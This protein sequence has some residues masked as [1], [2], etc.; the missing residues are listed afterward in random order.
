[1]TAGTVSAATAV[2][3]G[4]GAD[5]AVGLGR[6]AACA[7]RGRVLSALG[8]GSCIGLVM[9]DVRL[10]IAGLAHV[11]LPA[12][13]G[14]AD[15]PGKYADTAAPALLDA[16]LALGA[17]R[18]HV[19]VTIAGG[20]QMFAAGSGARTLAVGQRNEEAVR[21][22]VAALGLHVRGADT[23]GSQGRTLRVDVAS[24]RITVRTVGHQARAL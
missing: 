21:V 9:T 10:G 4:G 24:G 1:M 18:R 3:A 14:D 5:I 13:R 7:D 8:L 6:M 22:A 2:G 17:R 16:V 19:T 20:A 11:M 15:L 23:G 12:V